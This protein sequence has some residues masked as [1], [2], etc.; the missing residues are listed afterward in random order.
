MDF[1]IE[2]AMPAIL[3]V[4]FLFLFCI[5]FAVYY[6]ACKQAEVYNKSHYP[7]YSCSDF[8]WAGKQINSQTQTVNL[9]AK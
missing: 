1:I 3:V 9:I 4:S 2:K 7:N 8:F 6:S 5:P